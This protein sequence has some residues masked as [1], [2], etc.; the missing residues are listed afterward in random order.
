MELIE[1]LEWKDLGSHKYDA[2]NEFLDLEWQYRVR[3][4]EYALGDLESMAVEESQCMRR[5]FQQAPERIEAGNVGD[6]LKQDLWW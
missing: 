1:T 2:A 5:C 4:G 3:T 6:D